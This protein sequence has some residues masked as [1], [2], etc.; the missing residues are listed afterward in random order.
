MDGWIEQDLCVVGSK[1]SP[2]HLFWIY[3]GNE[4][5]MEPM[6]AASSG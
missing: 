2:A 4:I 6:L 5:S 1:I 3:V